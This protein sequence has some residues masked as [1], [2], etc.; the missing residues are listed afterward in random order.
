MKFGFVDEHRRIWPVR[1]MCA[2]LRLSVSGDLIFGLLPLVIAGG[3]GALSR[4]A[5][6]TPVFGG[7]MAAALPRVSLT[8]LNPH[9]PDEVVILS[10]FEA[11]L[12]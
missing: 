12:I 4:C 5:V 10:A 9:S 11:V 7:M 8:G 1:V 6:G 2:T 3:A